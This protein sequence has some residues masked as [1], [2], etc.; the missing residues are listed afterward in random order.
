MKKKTVYCCIVLLACLFLSGCGS[1]AAQT[2]DTRTCAEIA[3]E[4]QQAAGFRELT[5]MTEK[6]M[7][8][9]LLVDA[10]DLEEWVMRR[11]ASK[12]SP[13]M[14]ILLQVKEGMDQAAVKKLVQEFLDEQI[15]LFQGY[16]PEKVFMM[17][18]AKVVEK[19]RRIAL[20]VSP[21]PEKSSAALG[22]GW[23]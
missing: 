15:N 21:D 6:Y 18:N 17:K 13:E 1:D 8:K 5:D 20:F 12:A 19:G 2:A 3:D 10:A 4:V 14:V 16:Q 9:Y 7:E 11:D 22:E 23:K